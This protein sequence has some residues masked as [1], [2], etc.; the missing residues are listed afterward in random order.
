MKDFEN[1]SPYICWY[2]S[3][4][5]HFIR[6]GLNLGYRTEEIQDFIHQ[7][8]LDLLE[9]KIDPATINNPKAYLSTA[10][11]R[12]LIDHNRRTS[13][14]HFIDPD[15]VEKEF[16]E[17]SAQEH[18]EQ[19]QANTGL[20]I[21]LRKAYENLPER[22]R[23][24]V[25]LKFYKGLTTEQICLKTGLTKRTVY[26]NLF[27]AVKSL[28]SQLDQVSPELRLTSLVSLLPLIMIQMIW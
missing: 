10:F 11:T 21:Q 6:I 19:I 13:K 24:V 23:Q 17:Q 28:R 22:C 15:T 16:P 26:N 18:I 27:E 7:F 2:E 14:I 1:T 9:K 25:F 8:F 12:K 4:R 5:L 20:I 3:F